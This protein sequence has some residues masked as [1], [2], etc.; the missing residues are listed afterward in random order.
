M[1]DITKKLIRTNK[2]KECYV[3]PIVFAGYERIG[4]HITGIP[5]SFSISA[6][7]FGKYFGKKAEKGITCGISS[8]NRMKGSVLSP[9]V[10]ASA[11]YL[12]SVLAKKEAMDAGFDE[13]IM[14]ID[15][16]HVAEGSGE[17]LFIVKDGE[18][19]TPPLYDGILAGITRDSLMK[20]ATKMGIPV[21]ER[22]LLRDELYTADEVFLCGTAAEVT[23]V[24]QVDHR[25]ISNGPGPV[26]KKLRDAYFKIVRGQDERFVKWLDYI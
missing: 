9:H 8:W 24:R 13:A 20:I 5:F 25:R 12:N 4:L 15:S 22:S 26:T 17:N 3:R 1:C 23:P 2:V 11:N 21:H 6:I 10:K 18:L 16:G 19:I 14:L 7:P